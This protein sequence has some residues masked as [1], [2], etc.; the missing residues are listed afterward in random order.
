MGEAEMQLKD[1]HFGLGQR[2]PGRPPLGGPAVQGGAGAA[3]VTR[4]AER[5]WLSRSSPLYSLNGFR[6]FTLRGEFC[7]A[8][9]CRRLAAAGR[10]LAELQ[11]ASPSCHTQP[12]MEGVTR[13]RLLGLLRD[14]SREIRG[15]LRAHGS[16][17]ADGVCMPFNG[18]LPPHGSLSLQ[19]VAAQVGLAGSFRGEARN[20]CVPS[21]AELDVGHSVDR[22]H[23]LSAAEFLRDYVQANKPLVFTGGRASG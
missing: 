5:Q 6:Y 16:A 2:R 4:S 13:E 1:G 19:P 8:R 20:P 18:S 21:P 10:A 22:V 3:A 15:E 11:L 14:L 23:T 17:A 7:P 9:R 12:P